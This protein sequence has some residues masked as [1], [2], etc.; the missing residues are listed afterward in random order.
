MALIGYTT[1]LD[2]SKLGTFI[3]VAL[4]GLL[5]SGIIFLYIAIEDEELNVELAFN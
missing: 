5:I 3:S 2:L 1:K 4:I